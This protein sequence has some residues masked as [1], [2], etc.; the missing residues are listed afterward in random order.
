MSYLDTVVTNKQMLVWDL[1]VNKK[2]IERQSNPLSTV[3]SCYFLSECVTFFRRM[4][5]ILSV[6]KQQGSKY[7]P[8]PP[9]TY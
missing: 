3:S 8:H 9:Y 4:S 7:P 1:S 6:C 5:E 2:N